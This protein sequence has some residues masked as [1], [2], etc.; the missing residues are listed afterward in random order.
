M[1]AFPN[2]KEGGPGRVL[3]R[4]DHGIDS[5]TM[6][7]LVQSEKSPDWSNAELL[8][9][10]LLEPPETKVVNLGFKAGQ[11]LRFRLLAN[12][13]VRRQLAE[14]QPGKRLGLLREEDQVNWL[15]RKGE[16][17][18]FRVLSC[19]TRG[20]EMIRDIKE[21]DSASHRINLLSVCLEGLLQVEDPGTFVKTIERGVGSGKGLGF[22]LLSVAPATGV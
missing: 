10:L 19:A 21:S 13:T 7:L 5:D 22:G 9:D 16:Q 11:V 4:V 18:G 3:F 14:R 17:G 20:Q 2:A 8:L 1:R 6:C 12:P 15:R